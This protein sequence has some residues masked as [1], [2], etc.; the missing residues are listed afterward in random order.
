MERA[1]RQLMMR[2]MFDYQIT[3]RTTY[4]YATP[5]V[6]SRH[7]LYL[8]PRETARQRVL[9]HSLQVEPLPNAKSERIDY[10]GNKVPR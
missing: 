10:F 3:H 9:R 2:P 7:L 8:A 5:V 6:Q 4:E 1:G